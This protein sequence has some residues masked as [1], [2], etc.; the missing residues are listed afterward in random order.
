MTN[1]LDSI[2][3]NVL[4][5]SERSAFGESKGTDIAGGYLATKAALVDAMENPYNDNYGQQIASIQ[6]SF[7]ARKLREGRLD[8]SVSATT[9][10]NGT[11]VEGTVRAATPSLVFYPTAFNIT[12]NAAAAGYYEITTGIADADTLRFYFTL[13]ANEYKHIPISP[14]GFYILPTGTVK[15]FIT[16]TSATCSVGVQGVEVAYNG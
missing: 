1:Y 3:T 13:A 8:R 15:V 4:T 12:S 6:E 9:S 7:V 16:A 11:L 14:E 2:L 5:S 10:Y